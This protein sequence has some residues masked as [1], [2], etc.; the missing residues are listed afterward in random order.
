M[1]AGGRMQVYGCQRQ[2]HG[3]KVMNSVQ[4]MGSVETAPTHM[5]AVGYLPAVKH[6]GLWMPC[7]GTA[8][9]P[10]ARHAGV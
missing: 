3:S 2:A 7:S 10:S 8:C 1:A 9:Q 6:A 5:Y 4:A